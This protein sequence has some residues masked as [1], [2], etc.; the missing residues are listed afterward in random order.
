MTEVY[1]NGSLIDIDDEETVTASYGNV[2][3]GEMQK[4]KGVKSNTWTA[5]FSQ[6]NK[7]VFESC[8]VPGSY[9]VIPYRKAL[10]EVHVHGVPVFE[11]FCIMREAKGAYQIQSFA[12]ASDFN[13]TINGKKLAQLNLSEFNH[14]WSEVNIRASWTNT[15]G[16]IYAFVNYGKVISLDKTPPDYFLPQIYFHTVI[17]QIAIDAGYELSGDVLTSD[18]FLKHI[19]IPNKFPLTIIYGGD[20]VLSSLL[21]DLT[22]SKLWLD[23]ANIYGLQFDIDD[24]RKTIRCNYIDDILFN[25]PELWNEKIDLS[26][27]PETTYSL[28]YG[29]KSYLKYKT[30]EICTVAFEKEIPIDD[31]TLDPEATVYESQFFLIQPFDFNGWVNVGITRTFAA[32]AGER[33]ANIWDSGHNYTAVSK[34]NVWWNGS[35]YQVIADNTGQEPPNSAFWK[36]MKESDI[37]DIKSRPMYGTLVTDV[38]S[39]VKVY[40]AEGDEQ[41]IKRVTFLGMDWPTIYTERYRIFNRI[42]DRTK[43]I[44]LLVKLNYSDINQLDFTKAKRIDNELYVLE[45]VKQYKLNK[46]DSTLVNLIRI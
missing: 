23:F 18:K 37:W 25:E 17:K 42:I 34:F 5:P 32:K 21:P 41:V 7:D 6:R 11:G 22:Q 8:E 16:Y 3:F 15:K 45:E 12:G 31:N 20:F 24:V 14:V 30:D 27:D 10:I 36:P 13:S 40:F 2:S 33:D 29:Q 46:K 39:V 43:K 9:S 28:D 19:I 44:Q 4:R 1:I 35:Y 26:E 38:G